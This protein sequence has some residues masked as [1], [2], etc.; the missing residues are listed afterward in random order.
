MMQ[1]YFRRYSRAVIAIILQHDIRQITY[2]NTYMIKIMFYN[3]SMW[4]L[5]FPNYRH[6]Y[7]RDFICAGPAAG[8]E[9]PDHF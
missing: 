1:N 9:A 3:R 7:L 6:E 5:L 8:F 4:I 2:E